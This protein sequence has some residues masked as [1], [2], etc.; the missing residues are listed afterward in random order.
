[1][2]EPEST[3]AI[4]ANTNNTDVSA[5]L[6]HFSRKLAQAIETYQHLAK[7]RHLHGNRINSPENV[8]KPFGQV[9]VDDFEMESQCTNILSLYKLVDTAR[10]LTES[11][12]S[13][14]ISLKT[15]CNTLRDSLSELKDQ[16][17]S[18]QKQVVSQLSQKTSK[19]NSNQPIEELPLVPCTPAKSIAQ[20]DMNSQTFSKTVSFQL[21]S[22]DDASRKMDGFTLIQ[23]TPAKFYAKD[24]FWNT[25]GK[26]LIRNVEFGSEYPYQSPCENSTTKV[27]IQSLEFNSLYI[28]EC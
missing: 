19:S 15:L 1:M 18:T 13:H 8:S 22:P 23:P 5:L 6:H 27:A 16:L 9:E 10:N 14:T 28:N 7:I 17:D 2:V 4:S 24:L 12:T 26:S 3:K 25:P 11:H 20:I 21:N